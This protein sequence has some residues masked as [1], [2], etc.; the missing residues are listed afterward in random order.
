M[1]TQQSSHASVHAASPKAAY[2][3]LVQKQ[4]I[5]LDAAQMEVLEHLEQLHARLSAAPTSKTRLLKRLLSLTSDDAPAK[6]IYIWG[7][8][9]RGKSMLMDLFFSTL[10]DIKKRRVHF[11]RFMQ[12]LHTYFHQFRSVKQTRKQTADPVELLV[13]K[14]T[15]DISVLCFDELQA[16]D[17]TDATL[18]T[19]LFEGLVARGVVVVATSN[20]PPAELYT[21][22]VQ[23]ER[24]DR[25]TDLIHSNFTI[26]SLDSPHDYRMRQ[27]R[28]MTQT[29]FAPLGVA[30]NEF[31]NQ[32]IHHLAPAASPSELCL[33]V[34]GRTLKL[35][36]YGERVG[37]ASFGE[38]C[39]AALGA[40]DY[41]AI[42]EA[43]EVL[44]LT[45]IPSLT[46]ENRNEAKRFVT[47]IDALYEHKTKLICTAA[48]TPDKLYTQGHGSFEFERTVS[49]LIEM[50]SSN[51]LKTF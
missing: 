42:A 18:I 22:G 20:R 38:L 40:A 37:K 19:R 39:V 41:L 11:H 24:F 29:Y 2:A 27:L 8:V 4:L 6:G 21:G 44:I 10:P 32:A 43:L 46:P 23:R 28:S 48:A 47:L 3:A 25:L 50:Q 33:E 17:V 34:Q 1:A 14:L 16:T 36:I 26:M 15:S 35:S 51:Y 45:D 7:D 5:E 31:V 12:E 13:E 9:G 49:R 30:A